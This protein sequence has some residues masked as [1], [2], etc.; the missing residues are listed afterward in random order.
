MKAKEM[1]QWKK[2]EQENCGKREMMRKAGEKIEEVF[3]EESR[4]I[5]ARKNTVREALSVADDLAYE[6]GLGVVQFTPTDDI[7]KFVFDCDMGK[8]P[9]RVYLLFASEYIDG[10]Q[11]FISSGFNKPIRL[12]RCLRDDDELEFLTADG[13]VNTG[14]CAPMNLDLRGAG[15]STCRSQDEAVMSKTERIMKDMKEAVKML[16]LDGEAAFNFCKFYGYCFGMDLYW[17]L[18]GYEAQDF[19]DYEEVRMSFPD[20]DDEHIHVIREWSYCLS[21]SF[22]STDIYLERRK[23]EVSPTITEFLTENEVGIY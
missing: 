9:A 1:Y 3:S 16:G 4:W 15:Y 18:C 6:A 20:V 17:G 23:L 14:E 8:W 11:Y 13:W 12:A 10:F 2:E 5:D 21:N 22:D 7:L 19:C